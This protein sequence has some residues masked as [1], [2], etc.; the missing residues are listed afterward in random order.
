[1]LGDQGGHETTV[2]LVTEAK[3]AISPDSVTVDDIAPDNV[4]A[5]SQHAIDAYV[6]KNL[7]GAEKIA[8]ILTAGTGYGDTKGKA[9]ERAKR[10]AAAIG[11]NVI[12]IV[13]NQ[14]SSSVFDNVYGSDS[15]TLRVLAYYKK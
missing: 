7:K 9:I 11:A 13:G 10:R 2:N 3:P 4:T 5:V 8:D 12:L 15:T 14:K 6:E 1:M